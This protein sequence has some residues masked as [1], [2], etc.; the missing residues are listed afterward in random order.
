MVQRIAAGVHSPPGGAL[1]RRC[2][3]GMPHQWFHRSPPRS[4]ADDSQL[5]GLGGSHPQPRLR[6]ATGLVQ[7]PATSHSGLPDVCGAGGGE[8]FDDGNLVWCRGRGGHSPWPNSAPTPRNSAR[9]FGPNSGPA[10]PSE[11][12]WCQPRQHDCS[13]IRSSVADTLAHFD[14]VVVGGGPISA[15]LER[16]A[17]DTAVHLVRSYGL[18]ETCGGVVHDGRPLPGVSGPVVDGEL[19]VGGPMVAD[20]YTDAPLPRVERPFPHRRSRA[21]IAADGTVTISG[22]ID[23]V[24][25]IKGSNVDR[26]AVAR[27]LSGVSGV[28]DCAVVAL[29]HPIDGHHLAALPL[30]ARRRRR[31][32]ARQRRPNSAALR[33]RRFAGCRSCRCYRVAKLISRH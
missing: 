25:A 6:P 12:C 18:T 2:R 22:R 29:P 15:H 9:E 8:R 32:C 16:M 26:A 30:W 10:P 3:S 13:P 20:T 24:V 27:V 1:A 31:C 4:R 23:E 17:Q 33:Y 19:T 21:T 11:W 7:L 28:R 14:T 5:T